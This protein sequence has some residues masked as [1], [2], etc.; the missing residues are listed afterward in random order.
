[1]I[2]VP[3]KPPK[4]KEPDDN[5]LLLVSLAK[6]GKMLDLSARTVLRLSQA[7]SLPPLIK[8]GHSVKINRQAIID[9]IARLNIMGVSL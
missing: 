5:S 1:M 8:L 9:Y 6:A 2:K 4:S 7:G 3:P